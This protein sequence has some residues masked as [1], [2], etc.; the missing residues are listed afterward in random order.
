MLPGSFTP[1]PVVTFTSRVTVAGVDHPFVSVSLDGD[2]RSDLPSQLV[3]SS[4]GIDR[5]GTVVWQ[6]GP[7][8]ADRPVTPFREWGLGRPRRGDR[9]VVWE[10]D[11][12]TE[13]PRF[14]GLIDETSGDVN[15]EMVSTLVSDID[16]LT[17]D[18]S[19][20]PMLAR[21]PPLQGSSEWRWGGLAPMFYA[22]AA[23]RVGGFNTTPPTPAWACLNA[24]LQGSLYP[25]PGTA[26]EMVEGGAYG[27]VSATMT[28]WSAPWGLAASDLSAKYRP[29][30]TRA[31]SSPLHMSMLVSP[32]HQGSA[33]LTVYYGSRWLRVWV[34]EG[35]TVNVLTDATNPTPV[36]SLSAAS[37]EDAQHV[38]LLRKGG[39]VTLR[40]D[41]GATAT[42]SLPELGSAPMSEIDLNARPGSRIA[43]VR[44]SHPESWQEFIDLDFTPTAR[45]HAGAGSTST[46]GVT[47]A[48]PRVEAREA[49]GFLEDL[50][51]QTLSAMWMDEEGVLQFAP[52][53][54]IRQAPPVQTITTSRDVLAMSWSDR[55]LSVAS[56]VTVSYL[57]PALSS[58]TSQSVE[59]SRGSRRTFSRGDLDETTHRPSQDEDWYGVDDTLTRLPGT[60]GW[61]HYNTGVGSLAGATYYIGDQVATGTQGGG[62]DVTMTK[63]GLSE[64]TVV[65]DAA[66]VGV[67]V[68]AETMTYPTVTGTGLWA[69]N[70]S[71]P[72]PVLRAWGRVEW[73]ERETTTAVNSV[74]PHLRVDLGGSATADTAERIRGYLRGLI[75]T[76]IPR[77]TRLEVRPDPRRQIGDVVT[78]DSPDFLGVSIRCLIT[79]IS[80]SMSRDGYTQ[81][82]SLDVLSMTTASLTWAEWEQ[83]L[84]GT[85][86]FAQWRALR[87]ANETYNDF[88]TTPLKEA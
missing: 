50:A 57:H 56:R 21:M 42:G 29:A 5:S 9:V 61:S 84:P 60:V 77:I 2:M 54:A 15:G 25:A 78:I 85:L 75:E 66:S 88:N 11:G 69:R 4:G 80:E 39:T 64:W 71:M 58:G 31:A 1:G 28:L 82:L 12:E 62:L 67:G 79:G 46:W 86:T 40:A 26:A 20:E 52:S 10:G 53:G 18:F 45:I 6:Q 16:P 32:T 55:V 81:Q 23:M 44:V 19:C 49:E 68:T 43:G 3:Q 13:W 14:T 83:A 63:T 41:N 37:F 72:L 48:H 30:F 51:S 38:M 22:D 17:Q 59:V 7:P 47:N 87:S 35:R 33:S 27:Q 74:G 65:H 70:T 24:P 36:C 34:T 73:I 76:A 8:V